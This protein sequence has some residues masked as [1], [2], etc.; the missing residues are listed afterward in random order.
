MEKIVI[1]QTNK[2][3]W[4]IVTRNDMVKFP[5]IALVFLQSTPVVGLLVKI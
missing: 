2:S 3:Y 1:L 4:K 5:P